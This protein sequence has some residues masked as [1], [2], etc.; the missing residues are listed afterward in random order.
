MV[1]FSAEIVRLPSMRVARFS[2]SG[3][4]PEHVA[5][6][7]LS[8]WAGK[9]GLLD[10]MDRNPVF[11][12]DV[13]QREPG[14]RGYEYWIRL[15]EGMGYEEGVECMDIHAGTYAVTTCETRGDP[16]G[17]IPA[18]W[19]RLNGWVRDHGYSPVGGPYLERHMGPVE[20]EDF[21]VDLY[22]PVKE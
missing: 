15:P 13:P 3:E 21:T 7:A 1:R 22:Y 20:G 4:N 17:T 11:G 9:K 16:F 14:A 19:M 8:T 10:D 18:T 2:A 6:E 5:F 12:F